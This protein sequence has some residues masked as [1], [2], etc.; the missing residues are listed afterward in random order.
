M[1]I[2]P[3]WRIYYAWNMIL[4]NQCMDLTFRKATNSTKL[5]FREDMY[6]FVD[7][8]PAWC[9][10]T[11]VMTMDRTREMLLIPDNTFPKIGRFVGVPNVHKGDY[12]GATR[13]TV[14][15]FRMAVKVL[16]EGRYLVIGDC[17]NGV[18]SFLVRRDQ[19]HT[20]GEVTSVVRKFGLKFSDVGYPACKFNMRRKL[21]RRPKNED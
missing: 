2:G 20:W 11:L 21:R 3:I 5:R 10:A 6:S 14:S 4:G 13:G 19:K 12:V 7:T 16:H 15:L 9:N 18:V 1:I 17:L 8:M